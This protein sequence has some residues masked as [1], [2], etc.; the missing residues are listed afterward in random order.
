VARTRAESTVVEK[1]AIKRVT[2]P[3][4]IG[5]D[6]SKKYIKIKIKKQRLVSP[7]RRNLQL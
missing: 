4:V 2:N 6:D 3:F 1:E 7:A 5:I